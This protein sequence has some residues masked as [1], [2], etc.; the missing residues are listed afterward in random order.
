M[1][2]YKEHR[3]HAFLQHRIKP[4]KWEGEGWTYAEVKEDGRRVAIINDNGKLTALGRKHG[5]DVLPKIE[6]LL[7]DISIPENTMVEVEHM[8]DHVDREHIKAF[9]LP[10]YDGAVP[11]TIHYPAA[12]EI[13]SD[14]GFD[15]VES[16]DF[17][18]NTTLGTFE[19]FIEERGIEGLILKWNSLSGWYKVKPVRTADCVVTD[20]FQG[21]GKYTGM[22]GALEASVYKDGELVS[23][24][25]VGG[26]WKDSDRALTR[27]DVLGRVM[28]VKYDCIL[29][30]RLRFPRFYRWRDDKPANECVYETL[31]RGR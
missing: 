23:I 13:M 9:A 30:D 14:M 28:E 18:A 21:M 5:I 10:F 19:E 26:G 29:K 17:P 2:D 4:V 31:E 11:W 6:H 22:M 25:H 8:R 27:S 20:Y 7:K 24:A 12:R 15:L 1:K 3:N 16:V